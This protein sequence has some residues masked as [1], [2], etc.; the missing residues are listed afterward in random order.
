M[1]EKYIV[2]FD[3]GT[4]STRT[5]IFDQ[6]GQIKTIAQKELTKQIKKRT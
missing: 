4:T 2:A 6:K 5:I 1:S 3:Q